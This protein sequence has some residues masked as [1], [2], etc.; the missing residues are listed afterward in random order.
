MACFPLPKQALHHAVG[1]DVIVGDMA[2]IPQPSGLTSRFTAVLWLILVRT[3]CVTGSPPF[4][5]HRG[6][7]VP[8]ALCRGALSLLRM[9]GLETLVTDFALSQRI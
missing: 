8:A 1:R 5:S 2:L 4:R 7:Y 9:H 3:A 6:D